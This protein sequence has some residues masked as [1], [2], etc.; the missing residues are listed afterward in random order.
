MEIF[1]ASAS[2]TG[3]SL[4][5]HQTSISLVAEATM[6]HLAGPAWMSSARFFSSSVTICFWPLIIHWPFSCETAAGSAP[7]SA[8]DNG[9]LAICAEA[10][11]QNARKDKPNHSEA[12]GNF[13]HGFYPFCAANKAVLQ[14]DGCSQERR[15]NTSPSTP[16]RRA[17]KVIRLC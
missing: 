14:V 13:I 16:R 9:G 10:D 3:N 12:R 6:S 11:K 2:R 5:C 8:R 17:P 4:P 7:Q 15:A 1:R